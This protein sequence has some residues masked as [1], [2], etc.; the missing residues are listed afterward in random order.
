MEWLL[1]LAYFLVGV[2]SGRVL[3]VKRLG[4]NSRYYLGRQTNEWR[5]ESGPTRAIDSDDLTSAK[6]WGMFSMLLWPIMIASFIIQAPTPA[7][8]E[9]RRERELEEMIEKAEKLTKQL[10]K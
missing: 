5:E 4:R 8:K 6:L 7:E 3:F 2:V 10:R 9:L 1:L